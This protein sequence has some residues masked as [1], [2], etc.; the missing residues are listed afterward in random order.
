MERLPLALEEKYHSFSLLISLQVEGK[1]VCVSLHPMVS[2]FSVVCQT[3][4][5]DMKY[6][7]GFLA[8]QLVD[9]LDI[10]SLYIF[11]SFV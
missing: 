2:I 11:S 5:H 4:E 10:E 1:V 6:V 7:D 8:N 9:N 3:D